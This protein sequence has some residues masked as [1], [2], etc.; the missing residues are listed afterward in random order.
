MNVSRRGELRSGNRVEV[1]GAGAVLAE[2]SISRKQKAKHSAMA[3][4]LAID[5]AYSD[6]DDAVDDD[7][8]VARKRSRSD[9]DHTTEEL[10]RTP[11]SRK[12]QPKVYVNVQKL[13]MAEKREKE[14]RELEEKMSE[15]TEEMNALI[16]KERM[17]NDELQ[18]IRKELMEG[19]GKIHGGNNIVD[20]EIGVKKFGDFILELQE[21]SP[22]K[23]DI[24]VMRGVEMCTLW[25]EK[26]K[27]PH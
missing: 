13:A 18:G 27:D 3:R 12:R 11:S 9:L 10:V 7:A 4:Y 5:L 6:D 1:E 24:I 25:Q 17:S 19:L 20:V 15:M 14:A 23:S 22:Q 21:K 2:G 26:I 16:T 8:D